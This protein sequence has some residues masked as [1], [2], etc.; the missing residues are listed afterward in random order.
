MRRA[1]WFI[2]MVVGLGALVVAAGCSGAGSRVPDPQGV[3]EQTRNV[4]LFFSTGRTLVEEPRLVDSKDVYEKTL[5]ELLAARP[6]RNSEIAIVQ[7]TAKARSVT[8]ERGVLTV[9]WSR[10]VLEF[11]AEPKEKVLALAA[12]LST[13]GQFP[14]VKKVRFTV[15]GKTDGKLD[16]KDIQVFWGRVSLRGQPWSVLRP[17]S[18]SS[19][20]SGKSRL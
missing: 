15:E 3:P 10:D 8:F 2:A 7:P 12:I 5:G 4:S 11:D 6:V 20:E 19:E 18:K 14:E 1:L 17:G 16:G 13:F 9:D